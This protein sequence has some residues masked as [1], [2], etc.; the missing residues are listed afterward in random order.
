MKG[1][2]MTVLGV[3]FFALVVLNTITVLYFYKHY[4]ENIDAINQ[5][6]SLT[7]TKLETLEKD[8]ES[9]KNTVETINSQVKGYEQNILVLENRLNSAESGANDLISKLQKVKTDVEDWQTKYGAAIDQVSELKTTMDKLAADMEAI[10][11][12]NVNLGKI[13]VQQQG[14]TAQAKV[15]KKK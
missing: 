14:D 11:R 2:I 15:S 9:F 12:M 6:N 7:R 13:A 5:E 8:S 3:I 1:K 10:R 4:N